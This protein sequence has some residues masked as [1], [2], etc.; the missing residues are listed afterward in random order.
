[1]DNEK[2]MSLI[3]DEMSKIIND[4]FLELHKKEI[5]KSLSKY[6]HKVDTDTLRAITEC[7]TLTSSA[8]TQAG[9]AITL[10]VLNKLNQQ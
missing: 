4:E 3:Q 2:V 9:V 1:M 6:E 5:A 10:N 7:S 8:F